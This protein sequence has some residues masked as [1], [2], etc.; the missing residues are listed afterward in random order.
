MIK[1]S[2]FVA[3]RF[4]GPLLVPAFVGRVLYKGNLR[5]PV[6]SSLRLRLLLRLR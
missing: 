6:S 5:F 3:P 4:A 2:V 1:S